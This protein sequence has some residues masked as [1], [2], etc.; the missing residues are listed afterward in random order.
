MTNP[1]YERLADQAIEAWRMTK[2]AAAL[3]HHADPDRFSAD[4]T[5][6]THVLRTRGDAIVTI[7]SVVATMDGPEAPR[8]CALMA[9]RLMAPDI[10]TFTADSYMRTA[11]DMSEAA[12]VK[13][14]DMRRAWE[15]GERTRVTEALT[16]QVVGRSDSALRT[17][18]YEATDVFVKFGP[19]DKASAADTR[20]AV[21]QCLHARW[22][23]R[24]NEL[25]ESIE[26]QVAE[27]YPPAEVEHYSDLIAASLIEDAGYTVIFAED[28]P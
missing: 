7:A 5:A 28:L 15:R 9:S 18:P 20:G 10:L 27:N 22:E 12:D 14:G 3:H 16:A 24:G 11:M 2:T 6:M 26:R 4:L 13:P 17:L 8:H 23:P 19:V 1:I 25:R 21:H